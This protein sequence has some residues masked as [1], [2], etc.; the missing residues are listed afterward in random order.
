MNMDSLGNASLSLCWCRYAQVLPLALSWENKLERRIVKD[1]W[2][3]RIFY[4]QVNYDGTIPHL[5]WS[6]CLPGV[7]LLSPSD[8]AHWQLSLKVTNFYF[9][10]ADHHLLNTYNMKHLYIISICDGLPCCHLKGAGFG[11]L[12]QDKIYYGNLQTFKI[13]IQNFLPPSRDPKHYS[14]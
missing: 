5:N 3:P 6:A 4:L 12:K 8:M 9:T 10:S 11:S 13:G 14:L 1:F 7:A 2:T